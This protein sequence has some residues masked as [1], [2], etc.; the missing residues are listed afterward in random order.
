MGKSPE[1]KSGCVHYIH[2]QHFL[3]QYRMLHQGDD[4]PQHFPEHQ[5]KHPVGTGKCSSTA[6]VG[7][8]C[9]G[10]SAGKSLL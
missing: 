2:L 1:R 5:G 6:P 3:G 8:A 7:K 4:L 10:T 9:S